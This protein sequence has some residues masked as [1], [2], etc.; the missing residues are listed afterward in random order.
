MSNYTSSD[1]Q[2]AYIAFFGRPAEPA[3]LVYWM[4]VTES[5]TLEQMH[6]YFA[7]QEEYLRYYDEFL[8]PDG[9]I[10][11]RAGL[12]DAVYMNL[13]NRE[14]DDS[15]PNEGG[16]WLPLL[17]ADTVTIDDVVTVV[18]KGAQGDDNVAIISKLQAAIAFT[19]ATTEI[20]D[21]AGYAGDDASEVAHDWLAGIYDDATRVAALDPDALYD[22]ALDCVSEGNPTG[23]EHV[24]TSGQNVLHAGPFDTVYGDSTTLT[25]GDKIDGAHLVDLTFGQGTNGEFDGQ[26]I[27]DVDEILISSQGGS[28]IRTS[29][30][31]N[32]GEDTI[33]ISNTTGDV[34]LIDLQSSTNDAATGA[35]GTTYALEDIVDA[36]ATITL[37]FDVQAVD[38]DDTEVDVSVAE[39]TAAVVVD[40][41]DVET[42]N[43]DIADID[44]DNESTLADLSVQ[45][46]STLNISQTA[47]ALGMDF[48]ITGALDAG[49]DV[50]SAAASVVSNLH[51]NVSESTEAMDVTLGR[52]NDEINFGDTLGDRNEQDQIAGGNGTDKLIA[53]FDTTGTRNPIM[54]GVEIMDLTFNVSA[55]VDFSEV[56]DLETINILPTESEDYSSV[57]LIDMDA[58]VTAINVESQQGSSFNSDMNID[59]EDGEDAQL[60]FTWTNNSDADEYIDHLMFDEVLDLSMVFDGKND[61]WIEEFEADDDYDNGET[62]TEKLTITNTAAGDVSI[63]QYD[64]IDDVSDVTELTVETTG[65]GNLNL[66]SGDGFDC[67]DGYDIDLDDLETLLVTSSVTGNIYIGDIEDALQLEYVDI[68]SNGAG[69]QI[70]EIDA[71][72][73][74]ASEPYGATIS[75]FNITSYGDTPFGDVV[76]GS[77]EVD[78]ISEMNIEIAADTTVDI[79]AC[80]DMLMLNPG[81][82]LTVSGEGVFTYGG[83]YFDYQ[84]F[85]TMDFSGLVNDFAWVDYTNS[86]HDVHFIGTDNGDLVYSGA[87][88]Q[89]IE[90]GTSGD[91]IELLF[92]V[93]PN[94]NYINTDG[95]ADWVELGNDGPGGDADTVNVGGTSVLAPWSIDAIANFNG[96]VDS[97]EWGIAGTVDNFVTDGLWAFGFGSALFRADT[98][99]D[100]GNT[101]AYIYEQFG[102]EGYLFQ[103]TDTD[104]NADLV[105]HMVGGANQGTSNFM[106]FGDIVA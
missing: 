78:D 27:D 65:T 16:F 37:N 101:Y 7:A 22:A 72:D 25:P 10:A 83:L 8:N 97:I 9:T 43:L 58:T 69:I 41:G 95:G 30:W 29:R 1:V 13:F 105:I 19:E 55:T 86:D 106:S 28:E 79:N 87:G 44:T 50:I 15:N 91:Y 31:T 92:D 99:L 18:L 48:T 14:A 38:A 96:T 2:K 45:G 57:E 34:S 59:Y 71:I 89:R 61:V 82:T 74:E 53:V 40:G 24:L 17:I 35:M 32:I 66:A 20:G 54:S 76:I 51:L 98:L 88:N 6:A 49:L 85:Q 46:I 11:D 36:A 23:V 67:Y 60:V 103:D 77:I 12:L 39:V 73:S 94:V 100:G 42:L 26:V 62:K 80:E 90:T 47:G 21:G 3:G 81:D 75:E 4:S 64:N 102:D 70:D 93:A 84:A 56:D 5:T 63:S 68:V 104:G 52:G 33:T